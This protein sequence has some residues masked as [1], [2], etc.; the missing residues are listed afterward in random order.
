MTRRF[1]LPRG[2]R[3]RRA[4]NGDPT[5][6]Y[7]LYVPR[8]APA[9]ARVLVSMHGISRN[10]H[11]HASVFTPMCEEY[12][13]V[14]LVPIFT[15]D[16]HKDYQRLGRK[17]RGSRTDLL[18]QQFLVEVTFQTGVDASQVYLFGFS[19]GAQFAHRYAMA[20]PH[21]VARAVVAAA[22][23][24]T[25]PDLTQRFPYG[26]R[27]VRTLEG[28]TFNPEEFLRIPME[29]LIGERDTTTHNV[30]STERT[31]AQQGVNRLDRARRWVAAMG[32]AATS[33]FLDCQVT[34]TEVPGIGHSF[35]SFCNEGALVERVGRF[36]FGDS[37]PAFV[38]DHDGALRDGALLANQNGGASK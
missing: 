35:T 19:A 8:S 33:Y 21:R 30:R 17:G 32:E 28:V 11:E 31:V 1:S 14:M 38:P 2:R 9:D 12:G 16:L 36:L 7:I 18:L 13:V 20:H 29:L 22:G 23:W 4:L 24:Y 34:L 37:R 3:L 26:I 10:A 5:Q 25:F 27:P 6:E 15:K